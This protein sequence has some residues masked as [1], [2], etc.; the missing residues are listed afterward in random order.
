MLLQQDVVNHSVTDA[1]DPEDEWH[2][3][4]HEQQQ[5]M[6]FL[7]NVWSKLLQLSHE[8]EYRIVF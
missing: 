3:C 7:M 8:S 2:S 5:S 1:I 6:L 4:Q